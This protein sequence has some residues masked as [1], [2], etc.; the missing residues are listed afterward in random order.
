MA[1]L[2][3]KDDSGKLITR[4]AFV[5]SKNDLGILTLKE[6]VHKEG[7]LAQL[8]AELERLDAQEAY[9]DHCTKVV[10]AWGTLPTKDNG[11]IFEDTHRCAYRKYI[12]EDCTST[13]GVRRV[14]WHH[15]SYGN[16]KYMWVCSS[17][18]KEVIV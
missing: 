16:D 14:R 1:T 10:D 8:Q 3:L 5:G 17:H 12:A 7:F 15:D 2:E 4:W 11:S 9:D 6:S 13:E 18:V